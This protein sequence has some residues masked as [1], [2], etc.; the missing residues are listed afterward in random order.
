MTVE[1]CLVLLEKY[2]SQMNDPRDANGR[3]YHGDQRRDAISRSKHNY[4]MMRKRILSSPKFTGGTVKLIGDKS[5]TFEKHPIVDTLL[6][7]VK[8]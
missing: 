2:K 6:N 7:E 4:E 5:V 1:N 8:K 3:P